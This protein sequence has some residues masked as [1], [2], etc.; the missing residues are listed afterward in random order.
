MID[1]CIFITS[2]KLANITLVY[3]KVSKNSKENY[4]RLS[5]LANISKFTK[6]G[7]LS[8]FENI[9]SKFHCRFR[10]GLSG[11]YCQISKIEKW[12]KSVDKGKNFTALFT[13]LSKAFDCLRQGLIIAKLTTYG[14]SLSTTRL[15]QSYLSNK[16][17]GTKIN[18][19]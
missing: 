17:Q 18:T 7:F 16:K 9:F 3:K 15:M 19:T 2:L 4:T 8:N 6:E 13:D 14:F 5:N 10:Q 12:K 1:V 11:Q